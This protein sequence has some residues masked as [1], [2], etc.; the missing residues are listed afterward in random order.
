MN[1]YIGCLS[2]WLNQTEILRRQASPAM[3]L[4]NDLLNMHDGFEDYAW[5]KGC[6]KRMAETF[7]REDPFSVLMPPGF[8]IDMVRPSLLFFLLLC[9]PLHKERINHITHAVLAASR[10]VATPHRDRQHPSES[11]LCKRSGCIATGSEN[12]GRGG[13]W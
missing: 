4:L 8:D 9:L 5:L 2:I 10:T 6:R 11:R 12:R 3:K 7:P 13:S 1:P